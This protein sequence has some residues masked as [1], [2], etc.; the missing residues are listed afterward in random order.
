MVFSAYSEARGCT[1]CNYETERTFPTSFVFFIGLVVVGSLV[2]ITD[3]ATT[4]Y[5]WKWWYWVVVP[6]AE[7]LALIALM[8][9]LL[10]LDMTIDPVPA[11]C[12]KCSAEIE[13]K[14]GAFHDFAM[15]PSPK[16]LILLLIFAAV[17]VV[18]AVWLIS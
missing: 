15:I 2:V 9:L 6:I 14:G 18:V 1:K 17:H 4:L 13:F 3:L 8:V 16:E 12:P 5:P 11:K 10:W 7:F